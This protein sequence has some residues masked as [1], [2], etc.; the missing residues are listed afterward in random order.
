MRDPDCEDRELVEAV[1][2]HEQH[3]HRHHIGRREDRSHGRRDNDRIAARLHQLLASDDT[4]ALQNIRRI[5]RRKAAPKPK[6]N[7]VQKLR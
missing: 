3:Q 6:M 7:R 4:R 5:G 2:G 1:Q